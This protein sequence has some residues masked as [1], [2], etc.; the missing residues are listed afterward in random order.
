M[1]ITFK[2]EQYIKSEPWSPGNSLQRPLKPLTPQNI[3][4]LKSLGFRFVK[5]GK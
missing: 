2:R 1:G 5:S 3:R 4:F